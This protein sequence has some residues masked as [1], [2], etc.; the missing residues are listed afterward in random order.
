MQGLIIASAQKLWIYPALSFS[1]SKFNALHKGIKAY[2]WVSFR[3]P[4]S[5][6]LI[7]ALFYEINISF[8]GYKAD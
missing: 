1:H 8:V 4:G 5:E 2:V 3:Q 7:S 6:K